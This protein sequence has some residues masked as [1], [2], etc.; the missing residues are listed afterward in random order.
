M[1]L[2]LGPET[3]DLVNKQRCG[4]ECGLCLCQRVH[5]LQ[6]AFP[7]NS[8]GNADTYAAHASGSRVFG[9]KAFRS[10]GLCGE[11]LSGARGMEVLLNTCAGHRTRS[12]PAPRC[13]HVVCIRPALVSLRLRSASAGVERVVGNPEVGRKRRS[14]HCVTA[15]IGDFSLIWLRFTIE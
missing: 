12:S 7:S 13:C 3:A 5:R 10:R 14:R 4:C 8:Y 9:S 6:F 2:P 1:A 15:G 11:T